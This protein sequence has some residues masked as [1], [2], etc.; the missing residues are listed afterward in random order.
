MIIIAEATRLACGTDSRNARFG[1]RDERAVRPRGS[2]PWIQCLLQR[3]ARVLGCNRSILKQTSN[4]SQSAI[5]FQLAPAWSTTPS[6]RSVALDDA[7]RLGALDRCSNNDIRRHDPCSS[8]GL[9]AS[10][11]RH[12][13]VPP[14]QCRLR[15][16]KHEKHYGWA[17]IR[18]AVS[19]SDRNGSLVCQSLSTKLIELRESASKTLYR[20]PGRYFRQSPVQLSRS[21]S[22]LKV[23]RFFDIFAL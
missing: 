2:R 23:A 7:A 22:R 21:F 20:F 8:H 9:R 3:P 14:P 15:G 13:R 11:S 10:G 18:R 5:W 17:G 1:T 16:G 6:L 12:R 4:R 19:S